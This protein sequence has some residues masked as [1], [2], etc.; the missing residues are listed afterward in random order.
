M[1]LASVLFAL[2]NFFARS[3]SASA[4]WASAGAI[5]ALVGALVAFAV[6]RVRRKSLVPSDKKVLFW[7]SFFGTLSMMGTFYALS[8]RSLS[9]GDI[10]TLLNLAPVFLAVLAPILLGERTTA[11]VGLGIAVA[12]GGVVCVVRPP[13]VFGNAALALVHGG[14]SALVTAA[15]AVATAATTS[16]AMMML[17]RVGQRE[18]AEAIAFH[19]SLLAAA[20][21]GVVALFDFRVPRPRDAVFMVAGGLCAGF[22]QLAMTRAYTLEQ[23]ARVSAMGYLAVVVSA[24]LGAAVLGERPASIAVL[25]M[26][27]VIAGGVVVTLARPKPRP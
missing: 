18:S 22:A 20:T 15:I 13:F 25:G 12:L 16:L 24:L 27:L 10:V 8:S 21:L 3:A 14:P 4:S 7:R 11:A 26:F 9:L 2:M 1:A 23:A 17:R 19:F 6:A 5:R